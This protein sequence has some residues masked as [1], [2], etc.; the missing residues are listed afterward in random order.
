MQ[1]MINSPHENRIAVRRDL[2]LADGMENVSLDGNRITRMDLRK[3]PE[4]CG[5]AFGLAKLSPQATQSVA[6]RMEA[7]L[8]DG[9]RNQHFYGL[10]REVVSFIPSFALEA[11]RGTLQEINTLDDLK[12]AEECDF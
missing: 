8:T 12:K 7:Y 2:T 10:L 4:A 11:S 6:R 9:D 1:E 5:K 3:F